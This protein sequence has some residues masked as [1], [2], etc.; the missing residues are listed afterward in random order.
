MFYRESDQRSQ[1]GDMEKLQVQDFVVTTVWG[2]NRLKEKNFCLLR[3][4]RNSAREKRYDLGIK[5]I[6]ALKR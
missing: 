4:E 3:A 5:V 6:F 2:E 1:T